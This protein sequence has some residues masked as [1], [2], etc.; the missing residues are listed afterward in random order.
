MKTGHRREL[1]TSRPGPC[2][3]TKLPSSA[4]NHIIL[5]V[6]M[7]RHILAHTPICIYHV[8]THT[9][10]QIHDCCCVR[11]TFAARRMTEESSAR[12]QWYLRIKFSLLPTD[13]AEVD[14]LAWVSMVN[15]INE[16]CHIFE[17]HH[18]G[19]IIMEVTMRYVGDNI[20]PLQ[21]SRMGETYPCCA[22][23]ANRCS[24]S[25][26]CSEPLRKFG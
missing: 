9:Y 11:R 13:T 12:K 25:V 5:L 16:K 10:L 19:A 7:S 24:Q 2:W 15:Y 17:L 26:Y 21:C 4:P 20:L 14:Y 8:H 1:L 3:R 6:C 18:K 22:V 23:N